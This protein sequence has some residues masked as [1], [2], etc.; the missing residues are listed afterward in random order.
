MPFECGTFTN[1]SGKSVNFVRGSDVTFVLRQLVE[2]MIENNELTHFMVHSRW[3]SLASV[4]PSLHR[5][6]RAVIAINSMGRDHFSISY[7]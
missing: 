4:R 1:E 2:E 7:C 6:L 3:L 5:A